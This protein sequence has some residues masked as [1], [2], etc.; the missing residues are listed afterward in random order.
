MPP[1]LDKDGI[2]VYNYKIKT[3]IS[4]NGNRRMLKIGKPITVRN[5]STINCLILPK[6][7]EASSV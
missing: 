3:A 7:S 4:E 2:F 6:N 1:L 5:Y